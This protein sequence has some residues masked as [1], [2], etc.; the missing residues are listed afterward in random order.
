MTRGIM[1]MGQFSKMLNYPF[2]TDQSK[3]EHRV[4]IS[5]AFLFWP[6]EEAVSTAAANLPYSPENNFQAALLLEKKTAEQ[7]ASFITKDS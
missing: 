6:T 1:A 7:P 3:V 2:K 5:K 4:D